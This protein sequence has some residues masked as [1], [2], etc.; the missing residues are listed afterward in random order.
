MAFAVVRDQFEGA[1]ARRKLSYVATVLPVA[2]MIAPTLGS[3]VLLVAGWRGIYGLLA[4]LG[5]LLL[6]VVA[7]GMGETH[8]ADARPVGVI[9][10]YGRV[11]LHRQAGGFALANALSFAML[12]AWVSASPLVL[13][14]EARISAPV[15]G[16]L[17]ACISGGLLVGAWI[18]GRLAARGVGPRLPLLLGLGGGLAGSLAALVLVSLAPVSPATLVPVLVVVMACRG[19]A[20][21]NMTHATLDPLPALAG[22][23]SAVLGFL[24][25]A[26][27]AAISAVVAALYPHLG[28]PAV[29]GAMTGCALGALLVGRLAGRHYAA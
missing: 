22:A 12:F 4:V 3:L 24:S 15:Y 16:G 2:P 8:R 27:G 23:A 25:M 6:G 20:G 9:R 10:G 1:A 28:S 5:L 11:L 14:G 26:A 7:L 17:F 19:L 29:A 18:N 21:P 13:M